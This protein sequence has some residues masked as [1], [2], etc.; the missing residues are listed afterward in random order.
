MLARSLFGKYFLLGDNI[1]DL[2]ICVGKLCVSAN[3]RDL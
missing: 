2:R 3:V 1:L